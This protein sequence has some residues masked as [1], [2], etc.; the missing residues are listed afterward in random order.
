[1]MIIDR[2]AMHTTTYRRDPAGVLLPS[3]S[4]STFL[5]SFICRPLNPLL[6]RIPRFTEAFELAIHC[7]EP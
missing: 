6:V 7:E 4:R 5:F 3:V 1:M 2:S